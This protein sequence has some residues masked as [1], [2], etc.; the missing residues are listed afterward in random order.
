MLCL[1][2]NAYFSLLQIQLLKGWFSYR[3]IQ[4]VGYKITNSWK[5]ELT[6][7]MNLT[8]RLVV[9]NKLREW[10]WILS[11]ILLGKHPYNLHGGIFFS[12]RKQ[13]HLL[14]CVFV[15]KKKQFSLL[16]ITTYKVVLDENEN[17]R[18]KVETLG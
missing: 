4:L 16:L 13:F 9:V 15:S 17:T 7:A 8:A 12:M 2:L 10:E 14:T 3:K 6:L 5:T 18:R 11:V 1:N